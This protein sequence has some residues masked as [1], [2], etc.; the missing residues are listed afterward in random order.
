[1][2]LVD[3]VFANSLQRLDLTALA[4]TV[5]ANVSDRDL[6]AQILDQA[7]QIHNVLKIGNEE[8]VSLGHM[9]NIAINKEKYMVSIVLK[10]SSPVNLEQKNTDPKKVDKGKTYLSKVAAFSVQ[11]KQSVSSKR[12][13]VS[14]FLSIISSNSS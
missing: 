10:P 1:M 2:T 13:A 11:N 7:L 6:L 4:V 14:I 12:I 8:S 3:H 5:Q 9:F